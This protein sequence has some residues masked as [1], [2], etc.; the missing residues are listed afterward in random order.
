MVKQRALAALEKM[1]QLILKKK[2]GVSTWFR[3]Y[4]LQSKA[5]SVNYWVPYEDFK[6]KFINQDGIKISDIDSVFEYLGD[7]NVLKKRFPGLLRLRACR[8]SF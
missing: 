5:D 2:V 4:S 6:N 3:R 7:K 1:K 8:D